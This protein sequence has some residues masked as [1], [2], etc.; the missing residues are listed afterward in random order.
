M[1]R[2]YQFAA[3]LLVFAWLLPATTKAEI[4]KCVAE[5]GELTFSQV[6]CPEKGT[7]VTVMKSGG[8]FSDEP[9][10]CEHARRFALSTAQQMKSGIGS[11]AIFDS[12][13]GLGTLS[14]GSVSLVSYVFQFRTNVD[15]SAVRVSALA[16][17]KCQARAFG[18]VSCEQ[19]P[20][21]FTNGFGGCDKDE[22]GPDST[23]AA[24]TDGMNAQAI[25]L[26]PFGGPT[27][28]TSS[29]DTTAD[30]R[31][32]N[33]EAKAIEE[34]RRLE[35]RDRVKSQIDSINAGMR[36]GYTSAQG[37]SFKKRRRDLEAKMRDC[38]AT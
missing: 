2:R 24:N 22:D 13:G 37:E 30:M 33:R 34:E 31:A 12:Y 27:S 17:A 11:N 38:S 18:D 6:P 14:K 21:S 36:S 28:S 23:T 35:C 16:T 19:L 26:Q 9:A 3:L 7:T 8:N 15:V 1:P 32:R 29:R 10:D 20:A 25:H 4:F 5:N